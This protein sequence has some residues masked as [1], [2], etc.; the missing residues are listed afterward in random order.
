MGKETIF[1]VRLGAEDDALKQ[2]KRA[3]IAA[4]PRAD[5][6]PECNPITLWISSRL[7]QAVIEQ[8]A[9]VDDVILS[10]LNADPCEGGD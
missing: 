9:C 3:L 10:S 8:L 7:D 5:F 1:V 6:D 4:D 2:F